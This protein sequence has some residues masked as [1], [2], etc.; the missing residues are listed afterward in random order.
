MNKIL[1]LFVVMLIFSSC[2]QEKY[3]VLEGFAQGTTFRIVY[4]SSE[5][6]EI[7]IYEMIKE[8]D[9]TLSTYDKNSM[10]SRINRNEP[11]IELN[12]I[13]LKFFEQSHQVYLKSD[14]YFDVTIGPLVNAWGFGADEKITADSSKIDSLKSLVGM[15]K[16]KIE[17]NKLIK[18]DPRIFVDANAIAQGQ[19]VDYIC[20]F[21]EDEG[22]SD[23]MVE[24]GGEVRAKGVNDKGKVWKIGIDKP[25]EGAIDENRELQAIINLNNKALATSGNY[26]KFHE[27]KGIKYS[28]SI[29]PKTGYPSRDIILS[30]SII[31]DECGI[32]DAYATA[33]MVMGYRKA[34]DMLE[35]NKEIEAYIV[36]A[37]DNSEFEVFQTEGFK[38]YLE[39]E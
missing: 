28:H 1:V 10:L 16:I 3:Q 33:C 7:Q 25:V 29:N 39:K 13:F 34:K 8:F 11:N 14:G 9:Q 38:K 23:Y 19:S 21:F 2:I 5:I 12:E 35:Q 37:G 22:L 15:D 32:A 27:W 24:I 4:K 36:Y 6:Y 26:R 18:Q 31:A 17:N 20:D 30:A